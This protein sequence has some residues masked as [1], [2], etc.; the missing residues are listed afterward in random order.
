MSMISVYPNPL[1]MTRQQL[2]EYLYFIESQAVVKECNLE[3]KIKH[4][5]SIIKNQKELDT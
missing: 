1:Q 5:K 3:D 2:I 4:L